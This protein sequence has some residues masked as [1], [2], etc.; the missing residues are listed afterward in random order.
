MY[1]IMGASGNTGRPITESLL[2]KG[3]KVRVISRNKENVADLI[4]KGAE[5]QIGDAADKKFLENAFLGAESVYAMIPPNYAAPDFFAYQK[6]QADSIAN[7]IKVNSIKNVV[8][9]S[10]VGAQLDQD[11]GVVFGLR[12][13]EQK[14]D[15][16]SSLNK[17]HLRPTYFMENTLGM[18]PV[19]KNMGVMGSPVKGDLE[20]NMIATKDIAEYAVKRLLAQ[21]FNGH[22]TQYLLG[23]ENLTYNK[24]A[25]IYG[26]A[27]GK[28]ELKY[29][30]FP[31]ADFKKAMLQM[32]ASENMADRMNLFIGVLNSGKVLSGIQRDQENTTPT[33]VEEFSKLFAEIY[34]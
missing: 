16:I 1:V 27:I 7:A 15:E 3:K 6:E 30:E 24:V 31:E 4:Q 5:A 18:I 26:N 10:S 11:T 12:Y 2:E 19:I 22:N 23:K 21:D 33:S 32:G 29:V 9:L 25:E 17:L 8:T 34:N 13:L 20:L 28:K 14:L